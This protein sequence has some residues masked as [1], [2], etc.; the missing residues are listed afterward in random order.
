MKHHKILLGLMFGIDH[1]GAVASTKNDET[2]Y[3]FFHIWGLI[4]EYSRILFSDNS[5]NFPT[6]AI[7][8]LE[9]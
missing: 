1:T 7:P 4:I 8:T 2:N 5:I 9:L 3:F 6:A